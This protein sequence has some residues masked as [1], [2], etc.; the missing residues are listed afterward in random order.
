M[1]QRAPRCRFG[2]W[3][4]VLELALATQAVAQNPAAP[5]PATPPA[6]VTGVFVDS[7]GNPIAHGV[8]SVVGE[9]LRVVTDSNGRFR[10]A[11]PPGPTLLAARSLGYRPLMWAVTLVSGQESV[12]RIS[13]GQLTIT[14]PG[15]TVV[16]QAWRPD[17]L[18]GFYRRSRTGFGKY[19]GPETIERR[20]ASSVADLLQGIVGIRVGRVGGD[21][22]SFY[23]AFP[24][25]GTVASSMA[26]SGPGNERSAP[27]FVA[28]TV[29]VFIDGFRVLGDPGDILGMVNPGDVAAIEVYR[30]PAE[31]PAEFYS[32]DCA[33]ILIWTK[34]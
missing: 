9:S 6:I 22:L 30:G 5:A 3:A 23:I 27:H 26:P 16:A 14:L 29:G 33:A 10:L 19:I 2:A 12:Q 20:A 17:P 8:L 21:P 32:E 24:M 4:A 28:G 7:A 13:L 15:I 11:V 18:A 34:Y 31:L 1:P 25:C